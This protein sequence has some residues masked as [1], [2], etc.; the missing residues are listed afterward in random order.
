V[1]EVEKVAGHHRAP[2]GGGGGEIR[3]RHGGE[4]YELSQE[5]TETADRPRVLT[6]GGHAGWTD[7][8]RA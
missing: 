1:I 4:G 8:G 3:C 6:T 2:V 7:G 5:S